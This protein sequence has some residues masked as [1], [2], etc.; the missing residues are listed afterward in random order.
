MVALTRGNTRPGQAQGT[1]GTH[2]NGTNRPGRVWVGDSERFPALSRLTSA[3]RQNRCG[4][5]SWVCEGGEG[6][7]SG[8]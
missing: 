1:M 6:V 3:M 4:G 7:G 5:R 2:R 8:F